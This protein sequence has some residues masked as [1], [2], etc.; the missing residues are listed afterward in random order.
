MHHTM[1][2]LSRTV[3]PLNSCSAS[4]V[5]VLRATTE[6]SSFTASSTISLLGDFL[7]SRMAVLKSFFS[8]S[9]AFGLQQGALES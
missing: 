2:T 9:A 6:L 3:S 8:P 5:A 1:F 4:I 7:R